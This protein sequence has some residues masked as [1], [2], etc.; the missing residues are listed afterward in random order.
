M[1]VRRIQ[2]VGLKKRG[3]DQNH[4]LAPRISDD[5]STPS[6]GAGPESS[7]GLSPASDANVGH[8]SHT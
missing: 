1:W 7:V 8:Q 5:W 6:S 4:L 2:S 3:V